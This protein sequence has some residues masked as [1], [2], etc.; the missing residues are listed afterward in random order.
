MG[1]SVLIGFLTVR[2]L[3]LW[4]C[5]HWNYDGALDDIAFAGAVMVPLLT[6]P[7]LGL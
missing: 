7:S 1:L 5:P 6:L 4:L 3:E 2:S